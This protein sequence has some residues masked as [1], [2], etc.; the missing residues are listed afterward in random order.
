[1]A[2]KLSALYYP[3]I[4]IEN[5]GLLKNA[6]F[7]WDQIE[8]ICPF[9]NLP[10]QPE[11]PEQRA[12]FA[13]IARPL[14]PS[15]EEMQAAHEAILEVANSSL[16]DWFFPTRVNPNLHYYLHPEKFLSKTW[17]ELQRTKLVQRVFTAIDPPAP[18]SYISEILERQEREAY[19]T[20]EAFG[21]T[22]LS[23]LAD[24]CGGTT[25]Q[26]VTDETDSYVAL[27]RYLKLI[28]GSRPFRRW[29]RERAHERLVTLSIEIADVSG[30]SLRALTAMRERE[31]VQ[32]RL[33]TMR[34]SYAQK[35]DSYIKRLSSEA[36]SARDVE[37]I[38]R[39]F[40]K[41]VSDDIGLLRAELKD[42]GQKVL[43]SKEM[44]GAAAIVAAGVFIEPSAAI[45][46][47][48]P[49]YRAKVDYRAVR[50]RTLE[51]HSM[52]WLFEMR[53]LKAF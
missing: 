30:V 12:A 28:G 43:F 18:P 16:P 31:S 21:L 52:S 45:L 6:L 51:R 13:S 50:N 1:V 49:L 53:R 10:Y 8:L 32:P 41:E 46:A 9:E 27:D 39:L 4:S 37:E 23:I 3:H 35:I 38:E 2:A 25:K 29:S 7:L 48:A 14:R 40:K 5:E 17:E 22:M 44:V 33:R 24:C 11:N 19:Q 47:A 20:T 36:R 26:L 15:I 42:E 34:H